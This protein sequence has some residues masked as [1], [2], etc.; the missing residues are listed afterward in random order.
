MKILFFTVSIL[1]YQS[2]YFCTFEANSPF[3]SC[4]LVPRVVSQHAVPP[5]T[6]GYAAVPPARGADAPASPAKTQNKDFLKTQIVLF[7]QMVLFI[8]FT[9][10]IYNI[11]VLVFH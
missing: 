8:C 9:K 3:P 1:P 5:L 10:D 11:L 2:R 4:A 6:A 7:T